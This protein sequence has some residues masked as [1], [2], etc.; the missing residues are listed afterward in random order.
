MDDMY[1]RS[2]RRANRL[3]RH[4]SFASGMKFFGIT[5]TLNRQLNSLNRRERR[6]RRDFLFVTTMNHYRARSSHDFAV[7]GV[8]GG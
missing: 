2:R 8:P 1:R 6:E 7:L 4:A 5:V 3:S